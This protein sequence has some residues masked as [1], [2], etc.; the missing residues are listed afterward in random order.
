M[1][2]NFRNI[3]LIILGIILIIGGGFAIYFFFFRA[4]APEVVPEEEIEVPIGELPE[5]EVG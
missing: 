4:P 2:L 1:P 3:L 5:A